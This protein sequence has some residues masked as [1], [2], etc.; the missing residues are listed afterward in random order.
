MPSGAL[1]APATSDSKFNS[2]HSFSEL[3][4]VN[5]PPH[6]LGQRILIMFMNR[7]VSAY[8]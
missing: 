1:G 5:G 4:K 2:S 7:S 6:Y 8:S 3:D